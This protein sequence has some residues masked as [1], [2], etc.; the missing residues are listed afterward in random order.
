MTR[1]HPIRTCPGCKPLAKGVTA[2]TVPRKPLTTN[3]A[4][5]DSTSTTSRPR[6]TR[7][8]SIGALGSKAGLKERPGI[9]FRAF[10]CAYSRHCPWSNVSGQG[11][12][13]AEGAPRAGSADCSFDRC[14]PNPRNRYSERNAF[15][16]DGMVRSRKNKKRYGCEWPLNDSLH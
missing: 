3:R 15:C 4:G 16:A 5:R 1:Y 11:R 6:L 2:A 7:F 10:F 12:P 8:V 9:T 13:G 14:A